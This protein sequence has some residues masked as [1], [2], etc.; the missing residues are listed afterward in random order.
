MLSLGGGD[1]CQSCSNFRQ[2]CMVRLKSTSTR[3]EGQGK[4][5][6]SST[7]LIPYADAHSQSMSR[8][9][10][11]PR[12]KNNHTRGAVELRQPSHPSPSI[13]SPVAATVERICANCGINST[14]IWRNCPEG[15]PLCNLCGLYHSL[16]G[17][18]RPP[19]ERKII[20][21]DV[22]PRK[23]TYSITTVY[24]WSSGDEKEVSSRP[25]LSPPGSV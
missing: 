10:P 2:L 7:K 5:R 22:N 15:K 13:P 20:D 4:A 17:T 8:E 6:A 21:R 23:R 14:T 18:H 24:S 11:H 19:E 25:S 12:K 16:N 9:V 1:Q 3:Q